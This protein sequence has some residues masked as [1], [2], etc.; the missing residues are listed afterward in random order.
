MST[1]AIKSLV[2]RCAESFARFA[3][4]APDARPPRAPFDIPAEFAWATLDAPNLAE[5]I[6]FEAIEAARVNTMHVVLIAGH[7]GAGK[8]TLG[9]ALFRREAEARRSGLWVAVNRLVTETVRETKLG[10]EGD[11]Y[12]YAKRARVV[13]LDDLGTEEQTDAARAI[14]EDILAE[15]H[16]RHLVT[17]VT[18]GLKRDAI[19]KRY[20]TGIDRR[21]TEI[22]RTTVITMRKA[23]R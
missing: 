8:T 15:R 16:R 21:L 13:L 18:T 10:N 3:P 5:R 11:L 7:T 12:A 14:I 1:E 22:G 19:V 17:I 20:G 6:E 23:E 2:E 9:T 4:A